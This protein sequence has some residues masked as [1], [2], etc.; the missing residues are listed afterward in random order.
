MVDK[1]FDLIMKDET[2][3]IEVEIE[4]HDSKIN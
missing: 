4:K 2:R 3:K 1:S